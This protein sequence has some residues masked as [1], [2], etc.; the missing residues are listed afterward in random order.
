VSAVTADI[1]R[2]VGEEA[3]RWAARLADELDPAHDPAR[4]VDFAFRLPVYVLGSLLG[5]APARLPETAAWVGVE[6]P[7]LFLA[8][9]GEFNVG[10][11][12]HSRRILGVS[13]ADSVG[14][15]RGDG[16]EARRL[17]MPRVPGR[18]GSWNRSSM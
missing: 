1:E 14:V 3:R 6:S 10:L 16:V 2:S 12:P 9:L 11:A 17:T 8:I 18:L 7:G 4:V 5:V 13:L 15:S